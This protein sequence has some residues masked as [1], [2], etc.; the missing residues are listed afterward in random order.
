MNA[1]PPPATADLTRRADRDWALLEK[2]WSEVMEREGYTAEAVADVMR[3]MMACWATL[4]PWERIDFD[5]G[6]FGLRVAVLLF[7]LVRELHA[8]EALI[9]ALR[10]ASSSLTGTPPDDS[11]VAPPAPGRDPGEFR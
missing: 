6:S 9:D 5:D 2:H 7:R 10:R 1:A 8:K 4:A 11:M 3:K